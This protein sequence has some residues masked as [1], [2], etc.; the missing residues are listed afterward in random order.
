MHTLVVVCHLAVNPCLQHLER[1]KNV[2]AMLAKNPYMLTKLVNVLIRELLHT[3]RTTQQGSHLKTSQLQSTD[4]ATLASCLRNLLGF[5][6]P[7]KLKFSADLSADFVAIRAT[8]GVDRMMQNLRDVLLRMSQPHLQI[9]SEDTTY[10]TGSN[11][12]AFGVASL[13]S[14]GN[15][16]NILVLLAMNLATLEGEGKSSVPRLNAFTRLIMTVPVATCLFSVKTMKDLITWPE[17]KAVLS[18]LQSSLQPSTNNR[19]GEVLFNGWPVSDHAVITTGHWIY[20]NIASFA[21]YLNVATLSSRDSLIDD[22]FLQQYLHLVVTLMDLFHMPGVLQGKGS[23]LWT[24]T[25]SSLTASGIPK[26]LQDQILALLTPEFNKDLFHRILLPC[27]TDL[28]ELAMQRDSQEV[29]VALKST[30]MAITKSTLTE[31]QESA[32]MFTSK[33]ASK[34]LSKVSKSIGLSSATSSGGSSSISVTD[35]ATA[36]TPLLSSQ[37]APSSATPLPESPFVMNMDS[38]RLL[39][40]FWSFTLTLA[41]HS[42]VDSLPWKALSSLAFSTRIVDRLWVA[43][44]LLA[45]DRSSLERTADSFD[46]KS[47]LFGVGE[48]A[49]DK[50]KHISILHGLFALASVMKITLITVDDTELYDEG[51]R[52]HRYIN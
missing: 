28:S 50:S 27:R 16:A 45:G 33:W 42:K 24:R 44:C 13:T 5:G 29:D 52:L 48:R 21:P 25:G 12:A 6:N 7:A 23:V 18:Y 10:Y 40:H 11:A 14:D 43:V 1:G 49:K 9:M 19:S 15:A 17:F 31:Q 38:I 20:G 3:R 37:Q 22:G 34:L 39:C 32:K 30:A 41:S 8:I 51:V 26:A 35:A 4:E 47:D 36:S 2:A 46:G